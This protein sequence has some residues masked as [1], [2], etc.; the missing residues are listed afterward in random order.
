MGVTKFHRKL[1]KIAH[2]ILICTTITCMEPRPEHS[3]YEFTNFT[4]LRVDD[5][6]EFC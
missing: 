1:F 6:S 2:K 4:N 3:G 5:L